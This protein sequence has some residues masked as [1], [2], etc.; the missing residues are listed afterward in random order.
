MRYY[1]K[2]CKHQELGSVSN[3]RASRGRYLFISKD[4]RV[5]TMFPPLSEIQLN[6]SSVVAVLPLYSDKKVYCKFVYYNSDIAA[7]SNVKGRNEYRLY[8]NRELENEQLLFAVGDIVIM[9]PV[10]IVG[11]DD[12]T[13]TIYLLDLIKDHSSTLYNELN[14][15]IA[16]SD[17]RN[18]RDGHAIYEGEIPYFEGRAGIRLQK[19]QEAVIA[20]D[21]TV[22]KQIEHIE[23][24]D[25]S[26]IESLFNSVSFRD[27]VMVGYESLCAVTGMVIRHENLM[28][29]EAAHI[30]PKSHG[31]L[32]LPSNG[33]ALCRDIH[34][35]FDKGL[36]TLNDNLEVT[37]H[38]RITSEWLYFYNGKQIRIPKDP[39]FKPS[40]DNLAYHRDNVYGLFLTSGR[41]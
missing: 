28:N 23:Q 41:L 40:L 11:D 27:F 34:W 8:L 39:F 38:E 18:S 30:K 33:L 26:S 3:G 31:G 6:D 19:I 21:E 35:A 13:Q 7:P 5:L 1:I 25:T 17:V 2:K 14:Q 32:Y 12:D 37:V 9:R 24:T 36:F 22:T 4:E 20:I 10:E 15:T 16:I 29:L